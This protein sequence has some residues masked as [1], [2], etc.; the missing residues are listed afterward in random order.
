M[1]SAFVHN[2]ICFRRSGFGLREC[3][4]EVVAATAHR[5]PYQY[6]VLVGSEVSVGGVPNRP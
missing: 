4:A 5:F 6:V 3:S 2:S 1:M